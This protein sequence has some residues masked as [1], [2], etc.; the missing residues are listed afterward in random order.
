MITPGFCKT[1]AHTALQ[2]HPGKSQGDGHG[3]MIGR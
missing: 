2:T 1:S 3:E